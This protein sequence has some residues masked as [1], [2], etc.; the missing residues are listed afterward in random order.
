MVCSAGSSTSASLFANTSGITR[1][2]SGIRRVKATGPT[3]IRSLPE[4]GLAHPSTS[5]AENSDP[6]SG[7]EPPKDRGDS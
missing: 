1:V 3:C 4:V 5:M 2:P 7:F 6:G